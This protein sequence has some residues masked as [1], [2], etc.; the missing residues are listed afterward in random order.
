MSAQGKAEAEFPIPSVKVHREMD[1]SVVNAVLNDP[2][3]RP[4]IADVAEGEIDISAQIAKPNV[5]FLMGD[6]GGVMLHNFMS[7]I[8]E[9]HT[10]VSPQG[11]GAWAL[12]MIR[13]AQHWLFTKT[14]AFEVLTRIPETH[15]AALG[16]TIKAGMR[17]EFT[18][19]DG[20]KINGE[21][22]PVD[23]YSLTLQ[24]WIKKAPGLAERGEVFHE[25]LNEQAAHAG[26][27]QPHDHD[28][29]HNRYVGATLEMFLGG[30]PMKGVLSYNRWAVLS[31]HAPIALASLE[32]PT[33]R[34]DIGQIRLSDGNLEFSPWSKTLN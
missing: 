10:F 17:H 18:R 25:W 21:I 4:W 22:L 15:R 23:V 13:A 24:D 14:D 29:N 1:A 20:V 19:P 28:P 9:V 11:R 7:G 27:V 5:A 34:M 31:R 6:F 30:Q 32:P 33:I 2:E 26:H 3:V 12:G 16:L 8:Y